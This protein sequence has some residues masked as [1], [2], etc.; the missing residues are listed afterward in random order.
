LIFAQDHQSHQLATQA[1]RVGFCAGFFEYAEFVKVRDLLPA[2]IQPL[3]EFIY[4]T[5]WRWNSIR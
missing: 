3:I 4:I 5:G 2:E 1:A